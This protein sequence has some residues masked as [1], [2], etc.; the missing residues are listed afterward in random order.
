MVAGLPVT[1]LLV[2]DDEIDAEAINRAFHKNKV[3]NNIVNARDGIE[4]LDHLRGTNGRSKLS[5][6]YLILLDLNMPRMNGLEF[7]AEL[8]A[9]P[10]IENS[11]VF[12]LTTS[13]LDADK[14]AAYGYKVAGY[15]LKNKVGESFIDLV[16]LVD[17]YWQIVEFPTE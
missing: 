12:I 7:L 9:D 3:A 1:I 14:V 8:R 2:E 11:I 6:P 17:C 13:D 5:R 10:E 15:A 4:A 16:G